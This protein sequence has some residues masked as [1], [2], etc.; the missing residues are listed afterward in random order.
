[1][2]EKPRNYSEM[3]Q[4][5]VEQKSPIIM[6]EPETYT[7]SISAIGD[8]L[9]HSSVYKDASIGNNQYDFTK[10]FVHVAPYLSQSDITMANSESII[11]GQELGL[12]SYPQFNSPYE[13][14]DALKESGI[15]VVNMANNHTL[16]LGEKAILNATSYWNKLDITY[17]GASST[18][19][20]AN[21]IKTLTVNHIT[22]S[23][24]GYTYGTNGLK[25]PVGKEYLVNYLNEETLK[26]DIL[27]AKEISDI[28]VVNLHIGNEYERMYNDYQEEVAQIA[29]DA[30]AH[31]VFAHHPHVLQPA[32]WYEGING[33]KTFVIHSLGNF[34]S[35]QDRLYRQIGALVELEVTKTITYDVN[36]TPSTMIEIHH[37]K[38]LPTYVK[39]SNWKNYEILPLYQVT[40][41]QLPNAQKIYD[42]IKKHLSQFITD[43]TFIE[44]ES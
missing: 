27:R 41:Q 5:K 34:L 39:F 22:F 36:G 26:T 3:E 21:R 23:F 32:K 28:V 4:P 38:M 16:D 2:D 7:A 37:P 1:M 14:G 42:E 10:M 9:L 8:I 25:P 35:A 6:K 24:L 18:V 40:D 11:G 17:V 44:N 33:N 15:D 12:S 30:G 19:E 29:A 20:E 13:I 43:L 31:I